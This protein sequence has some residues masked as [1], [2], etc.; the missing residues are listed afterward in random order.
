MGTNYDDQFRAGAETC[1]EAFGESS[2]VTY[3]PF[4]GVGV[5]IT[6]IVDGER[7]V[8][9]T[10]D[11]RRV[12]KRMCDVVIFGDSDGNYDGISGAQTNATVTI[13]GELWDIQDIFE[14]PG[15]AL[16]LSCVRPERMNEAFI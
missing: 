6:A 2:Q 11:D 10:E 8:V 13:D 16:C 3:T 9:V 5:D 7:N 12:K 1:H 4:E 15:G 14:L